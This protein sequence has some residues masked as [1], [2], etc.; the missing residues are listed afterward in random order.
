MILIR[1]SMEVSIILRNAV[2]ECIPHLRGRKKI[3][4]AFRRYQFQIK[5]NPDLPVTLYRKGHYFIDH[6]GVSIPATSDRVDDTCGDLRRTV[7]AVLIDD[8]ETF[9]FLVQVP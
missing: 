9:T 5:V 8:E 3:N 6:P 4:D 7:R 1:V 2:N